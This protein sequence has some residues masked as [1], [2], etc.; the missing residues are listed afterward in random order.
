MQELRA[1]K[2]LSATLLVCT[3]A[4]CFTIGSLPTYGSPGA[5]VGI[6]LLVIGIPMFIRQW[7]GIGVLTHFMSLIRRPI[8][9]SSDETARLGK[10]TAEA[11]TR[12]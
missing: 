9:L 3:G 5:P 4:I 2:L 6:T 1:L 12:T 7:T 11:T 10:E 8:W